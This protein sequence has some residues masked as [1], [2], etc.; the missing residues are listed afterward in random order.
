[1]SQI[2]AAD[3]PSDSSF[4]FH[5]SI[6]NSA[7]ANYTCGDLGIKLCTHG[8]SRALRLCRST[9]RLAEKKDLFFDRSARRR[10]MER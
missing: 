3:G 1:M 9:R 8:V 10:R 4:R 7:G 6:K 5:P 2:K